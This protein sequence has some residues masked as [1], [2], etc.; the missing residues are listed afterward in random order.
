MSNQ[1]PGERPT[2][3]DVIERLPT[4]F[5]GDLAGKTR[6]TVQLDLTGE[7]GGQWW[8]RIADGTCEVGSGRAE[9]PDVVLTASA[10]DYVSIRLGK[11][12]PFAATRTKR[13]ITTGKLGIAIKFSKLFRAES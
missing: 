1:P 5:R 7:D 12:D 2:A 13:L 9:S 3:R 8:V 10:A 11:L 6:A 4:R